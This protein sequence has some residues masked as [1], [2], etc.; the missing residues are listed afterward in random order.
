MNLFFSYL[1]VLLFSY[2]IGSIPFSLIFANIIKGVDVRQEGSGNVGASNVLV[3]TGKRA[4]ALAVL[5]DITKGFTAVIA[6]R[7]VIG[8]GFP[9]IPAALMA[10]LGHDFP[11]YLNFKGGKGISSTAGAIIAMNPYVF[12][13]CLLFYVGFLAVTRYL[14]LS[15]LLTLAAIPVLFYLLKDDPWYVCFA[16]IALVIALFAHRDDIHRLILGN[17]TPL[18]ASLAR[19]V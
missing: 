19:V 13:V 2:L 12:A 4:A 15:S 11:V 9:E 7:F 8:P 18:G 10:I 6:A 16:A 17:E 5:C 3:T 14:I 1:A